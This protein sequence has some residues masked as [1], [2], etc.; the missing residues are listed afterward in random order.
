MI[1]SALYGQTSN[2]PGLRI[3]IY[4]RPRTNVHNSGWM[5]PDRMTLTVN[6]VEV[7]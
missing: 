7:F 1:V 4:D 6:Q 2:N 5:I 3:M